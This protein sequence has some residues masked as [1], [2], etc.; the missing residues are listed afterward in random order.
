MVSYATPHSCLILAHRHWTDISRERTELDDIVSAHAGSHEG[1]D[2]ALRS[3]LRFTT[4]Y[5]GMSYGARE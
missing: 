1:I 5:K 2:N 4:N 3:Y